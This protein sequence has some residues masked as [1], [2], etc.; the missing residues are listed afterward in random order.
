M[1]GLAEKP[2]PATATAAGESAPAAAAPETGTPRRP[3]RRRP[4]R[5]VAAGVA[6]VL[7]LGGGA[8][9]AL[10]TDRLLDDGSVAT[11]IRVVPAATGTIDSLSSVAAGVSPSV[12]TVTADGTTGGSLGSGIV[13]DANGLILTNAHVIDAGSRFSVQLAD[14]RTASATLVGS[15]AAADLA[16]LRADDLTGLTPAVLGSDATLRVGDAVLAFGSPLGLAGTVTS[17]IVS[18]LDR[19]VDDM[20]GLIQTDAAINHG[21]SGGALVDTA[22]RVVGIN[23][24]IA[25]TGQDEG[26][27]GLGFAIPVDTVRT[28]VDRLTGAASG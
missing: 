6:L 27:I 23:V 18:A 11:A 3:G 17:G 26:S 19:S 9:G 14:G 5:L 22:G 21:N 25:T 4:R 20:T 15:D 16:L 8:G 13:L 2:E 12:V 10:A 24:A 1:H 28:V 7:M